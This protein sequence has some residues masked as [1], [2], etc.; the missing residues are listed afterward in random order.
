[1]YKTRNKFGQF[2]KNRYFEEDDLVFHSHF[3]LEKHK[4]EKQEGF[5]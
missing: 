5:L 4:Q 3:E 1:M 2:Y